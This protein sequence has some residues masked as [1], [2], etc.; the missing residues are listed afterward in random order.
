MIL[1]SAKPRWHIE[2]EAFNCEANGRLDKDYMKWR[3]KPE[4]CDI[5]RITSARS[6]TMSPISWLAK[7]RQELARNACRHC[8]LILSIKAHPDGKE[9]MS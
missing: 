7:A 9:P 2:D 4:D 3:W 1:F 8:E 6:N 5:P